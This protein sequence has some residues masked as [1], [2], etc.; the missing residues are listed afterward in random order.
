MACP[1]GAHHKNGWISILNVDF[2]LP[3]C[4]TL[5]PASNHPLPLS[6]EAVVLQGQRLSSHS[7]NLA[8]RWSGQSTGRLGKE[9]DRRRGAGPGLV[10]SGPPG[11]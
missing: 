9:G 4:N 11:S 2:E 3:E 10:A 8:G 5:P 1:E 6:Q 7:E